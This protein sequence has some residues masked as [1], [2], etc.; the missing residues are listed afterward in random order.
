M[1][2]SAARRP[3][4]TLQFYAYMLVLKEFLNPALAVDD[5]GHQVIWPAFRLVSDWV[6]VNRVARRPT[7]LAGLDSQRT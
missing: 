5:F 2:Q 7:I 3:N 4:P 6:D 1:A